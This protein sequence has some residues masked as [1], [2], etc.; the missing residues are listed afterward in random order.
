[1]WVTLVGTQHEEASGGACGTADC[2]LRSP[3]SSLSGPPPLSCRNAAGLKYRGRE[4]IIIPWVGWLKYFLS[5]NSRVKTTG[6]FLVVY[7]IHCE[8]AVLCSAVD[9]A[10]LL[11]G[12]S[13]GPKNNLSPPVSHSAPSPPPIPII[14]TLKHWIHLLWHIC[15]QA[16]CLFT[17]HGRFSFQ[18]YLSLNPKICEM[19]FIASSKKCT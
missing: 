16:P 19:G 9:E 6:V 12:P 11:L 17:K 4:L 14:F 15:F 10:N 1:M 5:M 13:P 7:S 8:P 18:M 3:L 2:N